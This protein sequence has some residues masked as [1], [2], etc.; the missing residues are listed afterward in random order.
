MFFKGKRKIKEV[1]VEDKALRLE[2]KE[3]GVG[4]LP[5]LTPKP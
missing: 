5:L 2:K 1:C 3:R 4:I